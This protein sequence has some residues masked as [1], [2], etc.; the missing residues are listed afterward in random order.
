MSSQE[1]T[2]WEKHRV[3]RWAAGHYVAFSPCLVPIASEPSR[4]RTKDKAI[5]L[6]CSH[7]LIVPGHS[8]EMR[9]EDRERL[10]SCHDQF[11]T[12]VRSSG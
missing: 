12:P 5:A 11:G 9:V 1:K 8:V 10:C 3:R 7:P 2:D 6:G 4:R